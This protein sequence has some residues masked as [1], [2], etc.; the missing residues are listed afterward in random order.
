MKV[1]ATSTS[2]DA[3]THSRARLDDFF[4]PSPCCND[5]DE[6]GV[7]DEMMIED[8]DDDDGEL[9]NDDDDE[10]EDDKAACDRIW[11]VL[12]SSSFLYPSTS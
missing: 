9:F 10:E 4:V 2:N 1:I 6:D 12:L 7:D 11:R 8:E 3:N 5:K